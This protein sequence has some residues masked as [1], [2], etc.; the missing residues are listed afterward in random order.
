M[1]KP[2]CIASL[3]ALCPILLGA[4][5]REARAAAPEEAPRPNILFCIADDA[6]FHHFSRAGCPW[7]S[8]PTFDRVAN[9][10]LYFERCYTPNAKSAPSRAILLTGRYSWQL[11]EAGNHI[12]NFPSD[13]KVFTEVLAEAGYDVAFT[14]KGWAPGN[15]GTVDGKPRKLTGTPYQKA[16]LTPPTPRISPCDYVTNFKTFLDDNDGRR[17]WFFWFGSTEPHRPYTYGTG[18]SNG[19]RS[20]SQIDK[21]PAF[22]P[23]NEEVRN[24]LL[25]YGY[26]IEYYDRQI[27]RMLDELETRGI[28]D[29]TLV[30]ITSDNGMPFPRC[31][32]NDYEYSNHMPCAMMWGRG[33]RNSGRTVDAYVSFIDMAPTFLEL[34]GADGEQSG[35]KSISGKSLKSFFDD[36]TSRRELTR[37]R[38]I[39]LGRERDDYG[40]PN[41]QGYPIRAIIRENLLLIWNVKPHLMPAG[42]PETGYM[43]VDGSPTKTAVLEMRRSGTE[44]RFWD[45]SFGLRP[46]YELY[47]LAV[48][49]YCMNDLSSHPSM[50]SQHRELISSLEAELHRQGDPRMGADGDCFDTYRFDSDDKWNF[51]ERVVAGELHEP[52]ETTKWINPTDYEIHPENTPKQDRR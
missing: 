38:E 46:E 19:G 29:N 35:M 11:G 18:V 48:D 44:T 2:D 41:N 14:G 21:V 16:R 20:T 39:I 15:P 47:D 43:D 24:D 36:R 9:Q 52:W 34:A 23:D 17:P 13:L 10:G 45:L 1:K 37:R 4:G 27:G 22:W 7:V 26:E 42:N 50:A 12:C 32:A 49:P 6:S 25:D 31:K 3:T 5:T 30:V 28:L 51:Y 40:R 33:I 8:T